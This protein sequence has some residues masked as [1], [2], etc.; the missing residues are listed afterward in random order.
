MTRNPALS[1]RS[2]PC[3]ILHAT[4]DSARKGPRL[5]AR[6]PSAPRQAP[7]RAPVARALRRAAPGRVNAAPGALTERARL[8]TVSSARPPQTPRGAP[9]PAVGGLGARAAPPPPNDGSGERDPPPHTHTAP[10]RA[11]P[12]SFASGAGQGRGGARKGRTASSPALVTTL[13]SGD[14]TTSEGMPSTPN[15][16]A[17]A[18]GGLS[19]ACV[20]AR[21]DNRD[22]WV[23]L[24]LRQGA[25]PH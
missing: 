13:P 20:C 24:P 16:C 25:P 14:R 8:G 22:G 18:G 4:Q 21:A 5:C 7:S 15:R 17:S 9:R 19:R 12:L 3:K 23:A 11:P 2:H 1:P 6:D 10:F